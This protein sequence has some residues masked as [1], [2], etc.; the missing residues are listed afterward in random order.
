MV[1]AGGILGIMF[2]SHG[3]IQR[4]D[5]FWHFPGCRSCRCFAARSVPGNQVPGMPRDSLKLLRFL[6]RRPSERG[7]GVTGQ[8]Q[9]LGETRRA[10][11]T[12]SG[13]LQGREFRNHRT[14]HDGNLLW[15]RAND[16]R[17]QGGEPSARN[18]FIIRFPQRYPAMHP[19]NVPHRLSKTVL[20]Q[21]G[22][23]AARHC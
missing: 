4:G 15:A 3:Q 5:G 17:T 9:R 1:F 13:G 16:E 19:G 11:V 21:Q 7:S 14:L 20:R 6:R 12:A 23:G 22:W 2:I 18:G 10:I 8:E